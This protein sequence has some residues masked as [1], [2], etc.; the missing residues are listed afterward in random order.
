[1]I[2]YN[3]YEPDNLASYEEIMSSDFLDTKNL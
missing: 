3:V 2:C 1:M